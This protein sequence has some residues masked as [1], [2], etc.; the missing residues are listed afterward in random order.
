VEAMATAL[1]TI[2]DLIKVTGDLGNMFSS[3][4]KGIR[5][6]IRYGYDIR[7]DYRRRKELETI[8]KAVRCLRMIFVEFPPRVIGFLECYGETSDDLELTWKTICGYLEHLKNRLEE[9]VQILRDA[10]DTDISTDVLHD[11]YEIISFKE[12]IVSTLL[13]LPAPRGEIEIQKVNE[14]GRLWRVLGAQR[15]EL[16]DD[17][18]RAV[19]ERPVT[20]FGDEGYGED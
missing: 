12:R 1:E 10:M 8:R 13:T 2:L 4:S 9:A 14:V 19:G 17:L 6:S 3:I 20:H 16:I 18:R 5:D 15:R 11:L 7:D